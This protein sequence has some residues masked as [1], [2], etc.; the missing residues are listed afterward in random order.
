MSSSFIPTLGFLLSIDH[1]LNPDG[2]LSVGL[3]LHGSFIKGFMKIQVFD[4]FLLFLYKMLCRF[5]IL[6]HGMGVEEGL[7]C[8]F[9]VVI[10]GSQVSKS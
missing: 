6:R 5:I 8:V 9:Q 1:S 3:E 7:S 4:T 2:A 10:K